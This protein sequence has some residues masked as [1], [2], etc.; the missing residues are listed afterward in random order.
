MAK[1]LCEAS[2]GLEFRKR[3]TE[4]PCR[5]IKEARDCFG[6]NPKDRVPESFSGK[7]DFGGGVGCDDQKKISGP[8]ANFGMSTH[9][10]VYPRRNCNILI[11]HS[12]RVRFIS[13][14]AILV[15]SIFEFDNMVGGVSSLA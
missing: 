1:V 3:L 2:D 8:E 5:E 6:E 9:R 4:L 14:A 12:R 13:R 10:N 11:H 15:N 7:G